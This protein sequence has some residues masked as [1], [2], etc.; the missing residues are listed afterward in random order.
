ML[1][2]SAVERKVT[3]GLNFREKK[4]QSKAVQGNKNW[5]RVNALLE[6]L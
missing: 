1:C 4:I 5:A 2:S 6:F 3:K